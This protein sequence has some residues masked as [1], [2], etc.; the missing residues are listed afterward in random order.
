M[1][2][3]G[4][5][6]AYSARTSTLP[7]RGS[8]SIS[9]SAISRTRGRSASIRRRVKARETSLRSRVC[10]GG[11]MRI[12]IGTGIPGASARCSGGSV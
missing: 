12:I 3:T 11:S 10:S 4:R 9:S 1:T 7:D 8:A 2:N 5:R 6:N